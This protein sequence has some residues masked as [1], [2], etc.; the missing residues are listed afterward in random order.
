MKIKVLSE[1]DPAIITWKDLQVDIVLE[2]SGKFYDAKDAAKHT[3]AGAKKVI[4]SA[5]AKQPDATILMGINEKQYDDKNTI[6]SL[7]LLYYKLSGSC[8]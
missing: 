4:I 5:P 8:G 1:K 7:W 3:R 6:S 2:S